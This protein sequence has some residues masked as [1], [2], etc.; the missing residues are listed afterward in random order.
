MNSTQMLALVDCRHFYVSCERVFN[1]L[2]QARPCIVLSNND[3]CIVALS[4]DAK[5]LGLKRGMP[6]FQCRDV[7]EQHGIQLFSSNYSLY[8]A[9]SDRVMIVLK[10][11]ALQLEP[12][13]IDEAYLDVS[14]VAPD[15]LLEY[16]RVIRSTVLRQ[17]G[18]PTSVSIAPTKTL[19]KIAHVLAKKHPEHH[20]VI[21]LAQV[22]ESEID[23]LLAEVDIE[24][25][26]GIGPR[27]A[28]RLRLHGIHTARDL[29]Y[30]DLA[31]VRRHLSVVGART[32]LELCGQSCIP[33]E[34]QPKPKKGIMNAKTFGKPIDS[35]AQL[36]EA[37]ATYTARAAEKLRR[38]DS[39]ATCVHV[40]VRTNPFQADQPQYSNSTA[41]RLPF[42]TAFTA[43]F[44]T[45]A[46]ESLRLI[47]RPGYRYSKTGVFFSQI[48]PQSALQFDLFGNYTLSEH[49]RKIRLMCVIDLL[50]TWF[51][52]DTVFFG[53]QGINRDW[54][55]RRTM[56]SPRAMTSWEEIMVV[57]AD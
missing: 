31:W 14:H 17:T 41:R 1:A 47:Y 28:E 32:V 2:V 52:R 19:S 50:N 35:L 25:V 39:L 34:V 12:Y 45:A 55:M 20:D 29:K 15:A 54:Q 42:P 3:G 57:H 40:F 30:A 43:D 24:D 48:V 9:V 18:I 10:P 49:V 5:A 44:I 23:R 16:G 38:Q 27:Y 37:V 26:W 53:T 8:Q 11:F 46:L 21:S 36:E 22:P 33:L 51:G 7:V 6:L 13:S 56:L 4:D